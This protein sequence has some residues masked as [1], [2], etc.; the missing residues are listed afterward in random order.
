MLPLLPA[1][2]AATL[3]RE[4]MEILAMPRA[5]QQAALRYHAAI[6]EICVRPYLER[7]HSELYRELCQQHREH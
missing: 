5:Q 6:E 4:H 3:R 1:F 2:V 7:E